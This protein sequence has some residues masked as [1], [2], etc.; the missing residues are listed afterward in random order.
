MSVCQTARSEKL[1]R[2]GKDKL[3]NP[4]SRKRSRMGTPY[5]L[6]VNDDGG[7]GLWNWVGPLSAEQY[8]DA[9]C[10]QVTG[11]PVDALFWCGLQNPSGSARYNTKVG[12]VHGTRPGTR[13]NATQWM[14]LSSSGGTLAALISRGHDP[15]TLICDRCH[16]LGKDAWLS[17]RFNDAHGRWGGV[18]PTGFK[19]TQLYLDRPDLRMGPDHG[20]PVAWAE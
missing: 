5:R 4:T 20:W 18:D 3:Q 2:V 15:L 6:I 1:P 16:E 11:K 17:F 7:R 13:M 19:T 12:E 9:V 10:G 14:A 8:Q